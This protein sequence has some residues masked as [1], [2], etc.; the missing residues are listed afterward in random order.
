MY[1]GWDIFCRAPADVEID[2]SYDMTH[3]YGIL[4]EIMRDI[5][6]KEV[7]RSIAEPKMRSAVAHSFVSVYTKVMYVLRRI[8]GGSGVR[9]HLRGLYEGQKR[10]EQ[11][12]IFLAL[13][14]LSKAGRIEFSEDGTELWA[15]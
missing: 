10:S 11:V 14:E 13:L 15:I 6:R 9:I 3:D 8:H 12:A 4:Y 7:T 1:V 5:L 2:A